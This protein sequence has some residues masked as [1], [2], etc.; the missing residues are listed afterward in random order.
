[1]NRIDLEFGDLQAFVAVAECLSFRAAA[2]QLFI[3]QPALSRRIDKI[4]GVLKVRLLERNSRRVAVTEAGRQFLEHAQASIAE[5]QVALGTISAAAAQRNAV[6]TVAC[7]PSVSNYVLP[8]ALQSFSEQFPAVRL[9]V[10]DESGA[11]VLQSVVRSEAD[12]GVNFIGVQDAELD[13]KPV[14]TERYVLAV[15][16]SHPLARRESVTWRDLCGTR[17]IS[18]SLRSS[19]RILLDNA[20]A[21]LEER[22]AVFCEVNHVTAALALADAGLGLTA[23]PALAYSKLRYPSLVTVPLVEPEVR[24]T[25]GLITR[26]GAALSGPAQALYAMLENVARAEFVFPEPHR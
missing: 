22:P 17:L 14:Y 15:Q 8:R 11:Q 20:L 26:K 1:M 12:F 7:V 4:E 10:L 19:N 18:V 21:E 24:R 16:R 9:R 23:V 3:S 25:L 6:V 2:A 13:F 5:M